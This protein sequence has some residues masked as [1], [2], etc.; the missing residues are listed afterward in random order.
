MDIITTLTLTYA[1]FLIAAGSLGLAMR[2]AVF[3][4][5]GVKLLTS[6]I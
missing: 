4:I 2:A 3:G 1:V 5:A 6:N